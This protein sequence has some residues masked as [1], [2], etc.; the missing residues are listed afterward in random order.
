MSSRFSQSSRLLTR[1]S[2]LKSLSATTLLF[3]TAPLFGE[4]LWPVD[5]GRGSHAEQDGSFDVVR[6]APHYPDQ[7]PFS[8]IFK[9]VP[10]G[11]DEFV[12][13]KYAVELEGILA[14][15]AAQL[16]ATPA[17]FHRIGD[18]LDP[19]VSLTALSN[20]GTRKL[21]STF[22]VN[23]HER[24]FASTS[25]VGVTKAIEQLHD[26]LGAP[27]EVLT[28]EFEIFSIEIKSE[29]PLEVDI[30]LRYDLV[31]RRMNDVHEERVGTWRMQCR[32][33]TGD[34]WK[35]LRWVAASEKQCTSNGRFF[36]VTAHA[37]GAEPSFNQQLSHGADYWRTVLDGAIGVDVYGNN[38]V[39]VGDFDND[40]FDDIYVCQPSGLPNRLY[41]NRG[42]GTFEDVTEKAGVAVLDNTSCAIFADFDNRGLQDLL[43]VSGTG[44]LFYSNRGDGTFALKRDAFQFAQQ[45]Q[46]T[47]THAA[48][49][50]YDN[51]GRLDIYF[52]MYQ[53]YLGLDQYHYPVPYY[54]ARNGPPNSLFRNMGGGR[55]VEATSPSGISADNN[56]YSFAAAWG[57]SG[58]PGPP[59]LFIANDFGTS[60]LFRNNGNGTFQVISAQAGVEGVGAG[61]GCTWNDFDNDGRMDVYVPSMWEAAGQRI[62]QQPQFHPHSSSAIREKYIRHA[63][64]NALY[65]NL[66]NGKFQ[67]VGNSADVEMG[68]W[69]WS[70]DFFDFD[71]D[72]CDDLY[73]ANG[74]LSSLSR[75]DLAGFFWRQ[76]VAKS[77][78]DSTP[79]PAY[80]RGWSAINELVRSDYT[81]HGYARN[82]F[83]A[84]CQNGTFAEASG[85]VGLDCME[86][87][88]AFALADIDHDGRLEV[89]LKSRNAPQLRILKNGLPTIGS[90]ISLALLGTQSNRDAIGTAVTLTSGSNHQTKYIQAGSGFL[91][92]HSKRLFFGIGNAQQVSATIHWPS[93]KVQTFN[94]LPANHHISIVEG[95]AELQVIS[96]LKTPST[97]LLP[98]HELPS[99]QL[100]S[101]V[102]TWLVEPLAAPDFSLPNSE[103]NIVPLSSFAGKPLLLVFWSTT[104]PQSIETLRELARHHAVLSKGGLQTATI[105][106]DGTDSTAKAHTYAQESQLPFPVLF[107]TPEIAGVY[108]L[109]YRYL[110]DRRRD[111]PI[112]LAFLLDAD[113]KIVRIYQGALPFDHLLADSTS[114]ARTTR[115]FQARAL[116]FAGSLV[117]GEFERN[118]FTLGVAMYQHGYL[119]QAA[120]SFKQVIA[121]RPDNAEAYYNLGT[122]YLRTNQLVQAQ[123]F[124]EQTVKAKPDYPEAWNNLGM[125]A[126]QQGQFQ[127]ALKN[128]QKALELRPKFVIALVNLGNLYRRAHEY[129][130]AENCL[131]KALTIQPDDAE[132]NYSIGMLYAQQNRED[133]AE[134]FLRAA[135]ALRPAYPEALNNL[136]VFYVRQKNF[137]QAEQQFRTAIRVAPDYEGSYINLARIFMMQNNPNQARAVLEDLLRIHPGSQAATQALNQIR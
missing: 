31:L 106:L 33:S 107:A 67:N 16:K 50:D 137:V 95:S 125:L 103:G 97:F 13:E 124:L 93:G 46:G 17:N 28:A 42:N 112:P 117:Q 98:A 32:R 60:Q 73:V 51:D 74:Y 56:R 132:A 87:C 118:V 37:L 134:K 129:S 91:S 36:D 24:I 10:P 123:Q 75:E 109:T 3:R 69:S 30:S 61:M 26:W 48:V 38:G 136:G 71:H 44:P 8:D 62:S 90:S 27:E 68:R 133:L 102:A 54:D 113:S 127:E 81:W 22:G 29:A 120:A 57:N 76:V 111:L 19:S 79:T 9:L 135:I 58:A 41:R 45:P 40:G 130:L 119:E 23:V 52:C 85:A 1:R 110:F 128:F 65:R 15:W 14:E 122:L 72:G 88:R 96:F 4:S 47:F 114:V 5:I 66:G 83:F 86:D 63:R 25:I 2:L 131:R 84:N 78:E 89:I 94:N 35:V 11:S 59:D 116:P 70:S 82:V 77:P 49:G 115:Q 92:Q 12:T 99:E 21:R 55:F 18:F 121:N 7:S 101:D 6:Y 64:G 104:A 108:N 105:C 100:P 53:Y 126:A 39:A 80:E 43:V 20:P 34:A